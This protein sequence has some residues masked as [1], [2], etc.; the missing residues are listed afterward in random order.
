MTIG[1]AVAKARWNDGRT[2]GRAHHGYDRSTPAQ[3]ARGR[4]ACCRV[5]AR[6]QDDGIVV[7]HLAQRRRQVIDTDPAAGKAAPRRPESELVTQSRQ[8][9]RPC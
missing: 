8:P 1:V 6:A 7:G 9:K 3:P 4:V 2:A 5:R